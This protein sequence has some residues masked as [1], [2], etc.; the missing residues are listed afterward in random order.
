M[1]KDERNLSLHLQ[2]RNYL[3][4]NEPLNQRHLLWGQDMGVT[5]VLDKHSNF[6]L[7]EVLFL[8]LLSSV[9]FI[10]TETLLN[11]SLVSLTQY[12]QMS[13]NQIR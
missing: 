12:Y 8:T 3:N 9:L 11:S 10:W 4:S 5:K 2:A 13:D 1:G 6:P 7:N